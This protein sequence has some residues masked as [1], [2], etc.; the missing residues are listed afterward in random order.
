[1]LHTKTAKTDIRFLT[2][3]N[4]GEKAAKQYLWS[5]KKKNTIYR[6]LYPAKI[7]SKIKGEMK[8]FFRH[9]SWKKIY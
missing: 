4:T 8:T 6:I 7:S 9:K 2:K 3:N 5:T 1:M